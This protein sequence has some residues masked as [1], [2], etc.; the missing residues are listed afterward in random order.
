MKSTSPAIRRDMA[1]HQAPV[2]L[3]VTVAAILLLAFA[4][5]VFRSWH[6]LF[7]MHPWMGDWGITEYM[8]NWEGG[9]VRRGLLGQGLYE[10]CRVTGLSML[11]FIYPFCSVCYVLVT[12][13]LCW[14]FHRRGYC[15]WLPFIPYLCGFWGFFVRKDFLLIGIMLVSFYI[16]G[17]GLTARRV[18][19]VTLLTVLALFLHE[20][21]IFWGFPLLLLVISGDRRRGVAYAVVSLAVFALLSCFKGSPEIAA[22]ITASWHELLPDL[23]PLSPDGTVE[24]LGWSFRYAMER[25]MEA[26]FCGSY[27]LQFVRVPK[28][29]MHLIVLLCSFYLALNLLRYFRAKRTSFVPERR[30]SV[31]ICLMTVWCFMLPMFIVLSTDYPRLWQSIFCAVFGCYLL[32]PGAMIRAAIPKCIT[33]GLTRCMNGFD[34]VLRPNVW[35]TAVITV[36]L[37][38]YSWGWDLVAFMYSSPL[39]SLFVNRYTYPLLSGEITP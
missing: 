26:N 30:L 11:Q 21:Y 37:A 36:T 39:L 28:V 3:K 15:W 13:S 16:I 25:H 5:S 20:A 14:L 7:T 10:L 24:S 8:I 27:D 31:F 29:L 9:F 23:V 33:H 1:A 4:M 34:T 2:A 35:A 6:G 22:R 18:T 19:L 32:V 12:V 17:K 38:A